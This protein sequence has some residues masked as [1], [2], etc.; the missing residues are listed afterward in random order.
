MSSTN[1]GD[2]TNREEFNE[3]I[4]YM[5]DSHNNNPIPF[6]TDVYNQEPIT[7]KHPYTLF[8]PPITPSYTSSRYANKK[9]CLF[10]VNL[11]FASNDYAWDSDDL[12]NMSID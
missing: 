2:T 6:T 9:Y 5:N 10:Y 1:D 4:Q 7:Y 11:T 3:P 8:V 12:Y